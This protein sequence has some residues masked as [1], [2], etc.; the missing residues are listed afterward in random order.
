MADDILSEYGR[1][2]GAGQKPRATSGGVKTAKELPYSHPQGPTNMHHQ[3]PGLADHTNHGT[4][5]TQG[6]H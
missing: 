4:S 3:G 2:S 6:K 5:G 1:D